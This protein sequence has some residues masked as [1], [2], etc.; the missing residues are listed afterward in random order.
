MY[1]YVYMYYICLYMYICIIYVCICIY[2][3][4]Y[5]NMYVL[6]NLQ[7]IL[8]NIYAVYYCSQERPRTSSS[9]GSRKP[10]SGILKLNVH[11]LCFCDFSI[12]LLELEERLIK[13]SFF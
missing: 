6:T 8:S 5:I 3:Y 10:P 2:I 1:V 11:I 13:S 4:I 7:L 9:K 12:H